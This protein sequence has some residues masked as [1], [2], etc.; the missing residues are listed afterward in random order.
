MFTHSLPMFS[1][2]K[3]EFFIKTVTEM[4]LVFSNMGATIRKQSMPVEVMS[5][6]EL[7]L[8]EIAGDDRICD[9]CGQVARLKWHLWD[10]YGYHNGQQSQT[11]RIAWVT[12]IFDVAGWLNSQQWKQIGNL[13]K[14]YLFCI[15]RKYPYLLNR[16]D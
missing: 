2:R 9:G 1:G 16:N 6:S 14:L 11:I 4:V 7:R 3:K 13:L 12:D 15:V 8:T 5:W 10:A